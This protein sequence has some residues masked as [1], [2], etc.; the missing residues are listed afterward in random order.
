[1]K[2][3]SVGVLSNNHSALR[4]LILSAEKRL[5]R[6]KTRQIQSYAFVKINEIV[7]ILSCSHFKTK[8]TK[9]IAIPSQHP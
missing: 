1:M 6:Y 5:K 7:I 4:N 2:I 9:I 3:L 8:Y